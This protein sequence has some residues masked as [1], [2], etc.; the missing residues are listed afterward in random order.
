MNR[1]SLAA[2]L[3]ICWLTSGLAGAGYWN[4]YFRCQY[5][6][7]YKDQLWAAQ[8]QGT[9]LIVNMIYGPV[10]LVVSLFATG[11]GSAGW[12]LSRQVTTEESCL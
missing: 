6:N 12:T 9:A 8:G 3:I 2:L 1:A 5:P 7:N 4:A 10:G 11:F